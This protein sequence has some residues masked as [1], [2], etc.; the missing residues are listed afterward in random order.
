MLDLKCLLT[1]SGKEVNIMK[2]VKS[3]YRKPE[4]R[5]Y[6]D[7]RDKTKAATSMGVNDGG[8]GMTMKS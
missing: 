1:N 4:I 6:G 3:P 8:S 7:L 2:K 5:V